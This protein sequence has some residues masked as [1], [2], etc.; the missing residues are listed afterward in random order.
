MT[1]EKNMRKIHLSILIK[2]SIKSVYTFA[3][4]RKKKKK[5]CIKTA[6]ATTY[7]KEKEL[8]SLYVICVL[9]K[10]FPIEKAYLTVERLVIRKTETN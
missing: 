6:V 10:L 8:A 2:K 9:C 3:D 7:K 4:H 5:K 1:L